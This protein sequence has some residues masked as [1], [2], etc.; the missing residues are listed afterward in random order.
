M[1]VP[2][3]AEEVKP[4]D[5]ATER[6]EAARE[7]FKGIVERLKINPNFHA[8]GEMLYLWSRRW[9]EAEQALATDKAGKTAALRGH[10][11]RMRKLEAAAAEGRKQGMVPAYEVSQTRYYRIE[12]EMWLAA[13]K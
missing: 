13:V 2:S 3:M 4:A 10:V 11:E 1:S 5:L 6:L 9:M 7:T 8:S 12:A